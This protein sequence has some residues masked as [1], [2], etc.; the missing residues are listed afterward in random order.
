MTRSGEHPA[1]S[2][3]RCYALIDTLSSAWQA[4]RDPVQV[5]SRVEMVF[6]PVVFAH[7]AHTVQLAT[8]VADL[9][10]ADRGLVMM[11]LVRQ[12]IECSVRAVWLEQYR[13][14]VRAVVRE[15]YRQRRNLIDSAVR[16]AWLESSDDLGQDPDAALV[17]DDDKATSGRN[18]ERICSEIDGGEK[19]YALYRFASALTHPGTDLVDHYLEASETVSS[20]ILFI[21][22]PGLKS[23]DA[24][25][26]ITAQHALVAVYAWDRVESRRPYRA[27]LRAWAKEFGVNRARP[28]MTAAGF[29]AWN[30]AETRR[31]RAN[32]TQATE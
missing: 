10:R 3:E 8:A 12:V 13:E 4:D 16:A 5:T 19:Q 21:T 26:G 14:N 31:R 23:A 6:A 18:F 1:P 32:K 7:V 17:D 28:G 24:W 9:H 27:G 20:G 2:V 30:R 15:G 22:N 29:Q 25:L 11:P